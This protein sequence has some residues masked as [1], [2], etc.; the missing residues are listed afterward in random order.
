M[1]LS[2][3]I[4]LTNVLYSFGTSFSFFMCSRILIVAST[5]SFLPLFCLKY[6]KVFTSVTF[7]K[8]SSINWLSFSLIDFSGRGARSEQLVPSTNFPANHESLKMLMQNRQKCW[9][10]IVKC[11]SEQ[12]QIMHTWWHLW[13]LE[14]V[15]LHHSLRCIFPMSIPTSCLFSKSSSCSPFSSSP[16]PPPSPCRN[17]VLNNTECWFWRY[18]HCKLTTKL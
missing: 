11:R 9:Q 16:G 12:I 10:K 15:F 3:R 2:F 14:K 5:H 8:S 18:T 13:N 17:P 7:E 6:F 4:S 1:G